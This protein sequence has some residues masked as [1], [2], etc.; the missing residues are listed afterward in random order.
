MRANP[1]RMARAKMPNT[2]PSPAKLAA[3][4]LALLLQTPT[5]IS[6]TAQSS[7]SQQSKP[8][9]ER[10]LLTQEIQLTGD[11]QWTDTGI[12]VQPGERL[13]F[14]ASGT[15]RYPDA[16][17]DNSAAGLPRDFKDLLHSLPL[18][19]AGRGALIARIGGSLTD[20]DSA[21]P[22]LIGTRREFLSLTSGHLLV[23]INQ[24][25]SDAADGTYILR[26]TIYSAS[27]ASTPQPARTVQFIPGINN[28]LF[29]KIPRRVADKS[30][31]PGDMV[32]FLILGPQS[33]VEK[34]FTAAGW[35]QVD[36]DVKDTILKGVIATLSKEAYLTMPMSQLYL[37]GRPQ[38]HG[39]AH[40]EPIQVV[41]SRHHLRLWKAP[42][43]V[44]GQ[45]LWV[46]AA[47]HD[48]GFAHD[49]RN[50]SVTSIT[51]KIDPD[52][53]QERDFIE[54]TLAQTGQVAVLS[55]FLPDHPVKT[56]STAT[57]TEFHSSGQVLILELAS[58]PPSP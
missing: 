41:A 24:T 52:I 19:D 39:Y 20:N 56:A 28:E 16:K 58:A 30:G 49:D 31:T 21:S 7:A 46:G 32:N 50:S 13:L 37:F 8:A 9:P 43:T 22:F 6:R 27:P 1:P 15:L 57:G 12:D 25:A 38:D 36:A 35:V 34:V 26:I 48:I 53:D 3:A 11:T 5:V 4:I 2:S 55:H 33:A 45:T 18:N 47:T 10:P 29:T 40:A 17:S 54:K 44:Q 51:H 42:F 23:G 14:S